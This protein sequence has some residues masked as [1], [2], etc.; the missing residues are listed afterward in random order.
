MR[1]IP[2]CAAIL[3]IGGGVAIAVFVT[4]SAGPLWALLLL[5]FLDDWIPKEKKDS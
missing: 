3:A 4:Q 1:Y 2:L 5:F